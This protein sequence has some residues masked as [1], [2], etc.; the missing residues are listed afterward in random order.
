[1]KKL[2]AL[3]ALAF[4]F[5][6]QADYIDVIAGKMLPGCTMAKYLQIV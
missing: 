1:M 5:A 2:I 3:V 6:A 4:P